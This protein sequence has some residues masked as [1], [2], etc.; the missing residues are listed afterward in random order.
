MTELLFNDLDITPLHKQKQQIEINQKSLYS[1][2]FYHEAQRDKFRNLGLVL[3][4]TCEF[5][6]QNY[7]I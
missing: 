4:F 7:N 3:F 6:L 1:C 5:Q 2:K